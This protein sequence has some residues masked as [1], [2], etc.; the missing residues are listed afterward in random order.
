MAKPN[1]W[2]AALNV[3]AL[4]AALAM[5]RY[6]RSILWPLAA[7]FVI[8]ALVFALAGRIVRAFP[9]A[10]RW[11]VLLGTATAAA[12]LLAAAVSGAA[13]GV[14]RIV[15][16]SPQVSARIDVLLAEGSAALHLKEKV[17][18]SAL[19][20]RIDLPAL[21]SAL[22]D[23]LNQ[24]GSGMVL[25]LLFLIFLLG[26]R[27]IAEQKLRLALRPEA[28]ERFLA[29]LDRTVRGIEAYTW[30]QGLYGLIVGVIS[31][32]IMSAVGLHQPLF[33]MFAIFMLAYIPVVGVA[34]GSLAPALFALVQFPTLAPALVIAVGIQATAFIAGNLILPR[35][36]A[37]SV[38]IDPLASLLALGVW[39][40]LWGAPGAFLAL[41]LTLILMYQCAQF[42]AFRWIAIFIS[43]D[44]RPLP[45][46]ES[47]D[48]Q[49][50]P[51][52]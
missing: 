36:V 24:A 38:N 4:A 21:A 16:A 35:V 44:G 3:I 30:T 20:A 37:K 27:R 33:W 12:V 46:A 48:R 7:A 22:L 52:P 15:E 26:S 28:S 8:T 39:G 50:P 45:D 49:S 13:T 34:I 51:A 31:A 43:S 14:Q 10:P 40:V 18:V 32:V 23:S 41:P 29:V 2:P 42:P 6:F 47:P 11:S 1:G 9:R 5:L 25:M 19:I 17:S